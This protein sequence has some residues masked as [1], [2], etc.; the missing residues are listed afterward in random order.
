V[1][2][3][4]IEGRAADSVNGDRIGDH[5]YGCPITR[6]DWRVFIA[7]RLGRNPERVTSGS[8]GVI[9]VTAHASDDLENV[10][11]FSEAGGSEVRKLY[12][13]DE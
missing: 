5:V 7:P 4:V 10:W 3:T 12:I 8:P 2:F 9:R 1:S 6:Q 13:L 11:R